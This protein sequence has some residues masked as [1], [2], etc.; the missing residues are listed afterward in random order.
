VWIEQVIRNPPRVTLDEALTWIAAHNAR[1]LWATLGIV[2]VAFPIYLW[3]RWV[4][5]RGHFIFFDNLVRNEARVKVPWR[6][7]RE[8]GNSLMKFRIWWDLILF[9]VFLVMAI[10]AGCLEWPDFKQY[11]VT[12]EFRATGWTTAAVSFLL[13]GAVLFSIAWWIAS[14]V[15][16]HLAI[17]VMYVRKM[18]AW[19]SV[20]LAWREIFLRHKGRCIRYF[21]ILIV[22]N[23]LGGAV[24][25]IGMIVI[26]VATLC[27]GCAAVFV[28][29]LGNYPPALAGLPASAFEGV[30]KLYFLE[31]FGPEFRVPWS[32]EPKHPVAIPPE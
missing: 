27:L 15:V 25:E 7:F 10:V 30:Y 17:P 6:E 1:L 31:Q 23:A 32:G 21:L 20:K 4:N 5:A 12:N 28:P 24:A 9:N 8:L 19:P 18:A 13:A 14:S 3:I 2:I 11:L 16:F 29:I 26:T 22:V